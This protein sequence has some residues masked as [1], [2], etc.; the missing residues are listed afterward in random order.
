MVI[1]VNHSSMGRVVAA[2]FQYS[3]E[4]SYSIVQDLLRALL[5]ALCNV[6]LN[7]S[8]ILYL[9][10]LGNKAL[11]EGKIYCY[12]ITLLFEVK[13]KKINAGLLCLFLGCR[14]VAHPT[15]SCKKAIVLPLFT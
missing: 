10:I 4:A 5:N 11:E 12:I 15:R 2:F 8:C 6:K 3:P 7:Q 1:V 9:R 14:I 13:I